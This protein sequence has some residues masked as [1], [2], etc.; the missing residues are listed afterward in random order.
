[1]SYFHNIPLPVG[2]VVDAFTNEYPAIHCGTF[3]VDFAG[4]YL[5]YVYADDPQTPEKD[6]ALEGDEIKFFI[7]GYPAATDGPVYWSAS[8]QLIEICFDLFRVETRT[9]E[10]NVGKNLISWNLDTPSDDIE[11]LFAD[12]MPNVSAILGFEA[13]GYTYDPMYPE[14]S[15]LFY[16][17]HLHGYWVEMDNPD[18]L[19]IEGSPIAPTT[20]ITLES[21]WNLVSYLPDVDYEPA[22]ALASVHDQLEAAFSWDDKTYDAVNPEYSDMEIMEPGYGYWLYMFSDA[23]LTYPGVGPTTIFGQGPAKFN[24][25]FRENE[26]KTSRF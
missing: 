7:N 22:Y 16:A 8:T 3:Y 2:S 15:N 5:I 18:I 14:F 1:M 6:G 10:L 17:D 20:P 23:T 25:A 12:V 26:I 21:E 11:L 19:T 24:V 9:I 13:G 4:E